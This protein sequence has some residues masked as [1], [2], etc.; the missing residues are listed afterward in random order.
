MKTETATETLDLNSILKQFIT[1]EEDFI[2][3]S[4]HESLKK[5]YEDTS[6]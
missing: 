6:W 3:F 2:A 5:S 4:Y 1:Q